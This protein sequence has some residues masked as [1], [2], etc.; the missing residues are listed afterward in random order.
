MQEFNVDFHIHSKYS[1]GT[2]GKMELP[3]IA[4]QAEL[5]GLHLV[6]TGDATNPDWLR[7]MK[8]ILSEESSG[9]YSF[10][11]G[12]T[13][14]IV[15]SEVEDNKRVHHLIIFPSISAAESLHEMLLRH[16]NDIMRE[17]RPHLRI[18]GEELVDYARDVDALVGPAHVF[19]PWTALYKEYDSLGECYGDN[20]GEIKFVELGLSADTYMADR[21]RELRDLTFMSNS[22]THSPWPHRLG[23]EF[24]RISL[25]SLCFDEVKRSLT[26]VGGRG[27]VLNVGLNPREG[28][29]HLTACTRCFMKFRL[30]DAVELKW[31]CPECRGL[32]KKGV[33]DR[34]NE[35]ASGDKPK[36]PVHRPPYIHILPLAEVIS[37]VSG[38][39][40]LTSKKINDRWS[41][42]VECLGT[43]INILVDSDISEVKKVDLE[44]GKV[45]EK[46]R[47]GRMRYVAGGGGQ[48][49]KPTL[50]EEED[51]FYGRGQRHIGDF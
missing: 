49:G 33:S 48:Y 35:L 8:T 15:T 29:Y 20:L 18:N 12:E 16:S 50:K 39:S 5:K 25:K 10:S 32:I 37:L 7:H 26:N 34:I 30:T 6:G 17:G 40:T 31:R 3:V 9:V 51:N 43:E 38:I 1:G 27:V 44:V 23:R 11:R 28:K 36:H 21:I 24:N 4:K 47:S 14:F 46:F 45:I 41:S 13:R 42:L 2:S 19:T 22:D